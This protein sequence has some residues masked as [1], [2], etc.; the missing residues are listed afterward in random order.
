M[1]TKLVLVRGL[2]GSGKSTYAKNWVEQ[3]PYNRIHREADN[4]F[5][6]SGD[7]SYR[8]NA[9]MLPY[10]HQWCIGSTA[11]GLYNN[12]S[13]IVS[14]TFTQVWEMEK[15]FQLAK[16]INVGVEIVEMK[17]QYGNIH[18]VP[19]DKLD[20][21]KERWEESPSEYQVTLIY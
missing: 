10:A 12:I 20:K 8:F 13:I 19:Q 11:M 14:N 18:S 1:K 6:D 9:K 3:D 4:F 21:M 16:D 17:T 15:Y 7:N 5:I 2:P